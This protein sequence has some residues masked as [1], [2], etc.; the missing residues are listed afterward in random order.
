[1]P[2]QKQPTSFR[3]SQQHPEVASKMVSYQLLAARIEII[4]LFIYLFHVFFLSARFYSV[5]RLNPERAK[6]EDVMAQSVI[7]IL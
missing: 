1:M 3:L 7:I 2:F 6:P 4:V 5:T